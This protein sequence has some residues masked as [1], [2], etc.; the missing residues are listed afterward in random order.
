M[1][2]KGLLFVLA[3]VILLASLAYLI[4]SRSEVPPVVRTEV[5][6]EQKSTLARSDSR[7]HDH[8]TRRHADSSTPH[9]HTHV[10][11]RSALNPFMPSEGSTTSHMSG[12]DLYLVP[13]F[14]YVIRMSMPANP[15]AHEWSQE[16]AEAFMRLNGQIRE[17]MRADDP[18]AQEEIRRLQI[19]Q[20]RVFWETN[21]F[22][23][24]E[25]HVTYIAAPGVVEPPISEAIVIDLHSRTVYDP[26]VQPVP[27]QEQ[28]G[29]WDAPVEP[30]V[31]EG[32]RPRDDDNHDR[33]MAPWEGFANESEAANDT[34]PYSGAP[35]EMDREPPSGG[36]GQNQAQILGA[37]MGESL[38]SEDIVPPEFDVRE[39][40]RSVDVPT[41][42]ANELHDGA[43]P[44]GLERQ[45]RQNTTDGSGTSRLER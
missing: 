37:R 33:T 5:R 44:Q 45:P 10:M 30:P 36:S 29:P 22:P 24:E 18:G 35:V 31:S 32:P 2:R 40:A 8:E 19:E 21:R 3:V 9:T 13:G 38:S 17:A 6:E 4:I 39:D 14:K 1:P 16:D 42:N 7:T 27:P 12:V 26:L 25:K 41:P 34:R 11:D 43:V 23:S 28:L 20:E 15:D